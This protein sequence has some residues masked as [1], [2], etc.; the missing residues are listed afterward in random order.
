MAASITAQKLLSS[1][2]GIEKIPR[3]QIQKSNIPDQESDDDSFTDDDLLSGY[4]KFMSSFASGFNNNFKG[5]QILQS[6][7][8]FH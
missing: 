1:E 3:S 2:T 8:G 5:M 6:Q 7:V 4:E